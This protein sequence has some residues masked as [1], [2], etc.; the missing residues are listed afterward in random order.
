MRAGANVSAPE[1]KRPASWGE[2]LHAIVAGRERRPAGGVQH[3]SSAAVPRGDDDDAS[4]IARIRHGDV[5][6]LSVLYDRHA[7]AIYGLARALLGESPV[8]DA[9]TK[10]AFLSLW[11]RHADQCG[12]DLPVRGRL[13]MSVWQ[14]VLELPGSESGVACPNFI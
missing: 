6:A 7:P 11:R 12:D 5:D 4:L 14:E 13:A 10:N 3:A 8:A 9:V 2:R 1:A